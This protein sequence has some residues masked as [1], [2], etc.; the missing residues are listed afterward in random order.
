MEF[1]RRRLSE[2]VNP[3]TIS[4]PSVRRMLL[5]KP[6]AG[7]LILF[8]LAAVTRAIC[9][10]AKSEAVK[11]T[12][13]SYL[14]TS[15]VLDGKI[16]R[17]EWDDAT[18]FSGVRDWTAEFSP[19]FQDNDLSLQG[20]VKHDADWL[21]FGFDVGDDVLYGIDT[22][23]WLPD[24]NSQAHELTQAGF[25]WFGD[26]MEILINATGRWKGDEGAEGNGFSWQM[27]C[28]LTKSRLGGVG[29]G[30]LLEG[31][32]RRKTSAWE[33][34]RKWIQEGVQ[35]A[36]A[37]PKPG[38][39]GYVIEWAI[40]FEPCLEIS[41]DKF[42]SPSLGEVSVGLNIAIADLDEKEKGT[43]NFGNFHHEQWFSGVPQLRTQKRHWGT[44][45]IMG[46]QKM[47][48]K[49]TSK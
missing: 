35:R 11:R 45:Q 22:T 43:D 36:V 2:S 13:R 42:Y 47:T 24:E 15:P 3:N 37:K 34:Y 33:T 41:N 12:I 17:G 46:T 8:C 14:G 44:L 20:F 40:R 7:L 25:P 26:G 32:P 23:R 1:V 38:G 48:P 18:P 21:Y 30:G 4:L 28:N 9:A 16:G 6:V 27:V 39:K 31:E 10:P 5:V 49:E 29:V 19:V